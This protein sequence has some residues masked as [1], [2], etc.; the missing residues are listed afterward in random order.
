[1]G[2]RDMSYGVGLIQI[3]WLWSAL[4]LRAGG[5]KLLERLRT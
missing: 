5:E 1:M 4:C 2:W 3:S